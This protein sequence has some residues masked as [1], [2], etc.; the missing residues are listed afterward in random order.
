MRNY[1]R[2][3]GA[4]EGEE[5]NVAV[6]NKRDSVQEHQ[7]TKQRFNMTNESIIK[8]RKEM[9]KAMGLK[10]NTANKVRNRS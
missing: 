2:S 10:R 6:G 9:K 4:T 3:R 1:W 7:S 5:S 8:Q